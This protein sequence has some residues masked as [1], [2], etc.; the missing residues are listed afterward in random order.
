LLLSGIFVSA[1]IKLNDYTPE[2]K[3]LRLQES[4]ARALTLKW[5]SYDYAKAVGW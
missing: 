5:E 4:M 2:S 1:V 3:M